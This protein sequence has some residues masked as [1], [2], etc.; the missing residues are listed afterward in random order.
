MIIADIHTHILPD[1]DDGS[2]SMTQTLD[3]LIAA[4]KCGTRHIV[5]TSHFGGQHFTVKKETVTEL[6]KQLNREMFLRGMN[7]TIYPGNEIRCSTSTVDDLREGVA[8]SINF[9]K[10][11]LV[12]LPFHNTLTNVEDLVL[13]CGNLGHELILAHPERHEYLMDNIQ[14]LQRLTE[15]GVMLQCN[16]DSLY[17]NNGVKSMYFVHN[18]LRKKMVSFIASDCHSTFQRGPQLDSAYRI[19][20]RWYGQNTAK[21]LLYENP[22]RVIGSRAIVR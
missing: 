13:N 4:Y 6:T 14:I 8:C 16:A 10:Y 18:L 19:I 20:T 1:V 21:K 15:Y 17:G 11:V 7:L 22:M 2:E 3:M 9:G 5:A 12:E